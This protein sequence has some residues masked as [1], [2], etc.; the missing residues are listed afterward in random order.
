MCGIA[1]ISIGRKSRGRI[2]YPLLRKLSRELLYELEPRGI[3]ASGIA[4]INDPLSNVKS[5][6]FKKSLRSHRF[7]VRP[8]FEE[9]LSYI[10][11]QTNFIMLHARATSS[12]ISNNNFNNHPI[13]TRPIVGIHN[14]TLL[15]SNRLFKKFKNRFSREGDVDSEIIFRLYNYYI[16]QK[17]LSPKEALI[18]TSNKLSG[19]Y[20]GAMVDLRHPHKMVM[21]KFDR[22]LAILRLQHYDIVIAV[23]E[24]RFYD[25]ARERLNIRSKDIYQTVKDATGFIIDL[26]TDTRITSKIF[27]FEIPVDKSTTMMR[28]KSPWL[29]AGIYG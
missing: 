8:K 18:A 16:D 22:S 24:S 29:S 6:V 28:M 1:T 4:I 2:P 23:S 19:A 26:N 3:D 15:N 13:I 11:P 5:I 27:D 17:D 7:I 21:F 9:A 25:K 20:T 14:G 12:G 10:G